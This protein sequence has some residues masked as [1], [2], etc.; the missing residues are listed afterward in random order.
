MLVENYKRFFNF[1]W[2]KSSPWKQLRTVP[3]EQSV[4]TQLAAFVLGNKKLYH[5]VLEHAY[6]GKMD[7][8]DDLA[9]V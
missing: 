5:S 3:L 6:G 7:I 4:R 1:V 9:E 8:E 2:L